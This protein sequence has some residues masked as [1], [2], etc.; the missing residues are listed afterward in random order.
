MRRHRNAK[1]VATLGLASSTPEIIRSLFEAGADVF[2]LNFSHGTHEDHKKRYDIIRANDVVALLVIFVR[3][4]AEIEPEDI[5]AR[6]EQ[7]ADDLRRRTRETESS[8]D[9]GVAVSAH[10]VLRPCGRPSF[11]CGD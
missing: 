1:I 8:D 6:F 10:D 3:A 2:R 9:L 4:M 11:V 5:G 7:T